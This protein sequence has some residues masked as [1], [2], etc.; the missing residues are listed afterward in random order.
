MTTRNK[1]ILNSAALSIESS[2]PSGLFNL[3]LQENIVRRRTIF[4]PKNL[5]AKE[6]EM[7]G[8]T[9]SRMGDKSP[10]INTSA[11]TNQID[12]GRVTEQEWLKNV[13]RNDLEGVQS[14]E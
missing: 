7:D 13:K 11:L 10:R 14:Q 4:P 2:P 1:K 6:A 8:T 9:T 5:H 3:P 12:I